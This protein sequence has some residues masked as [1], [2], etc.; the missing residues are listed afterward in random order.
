M[1]TTKIV[2]A[3]KTLNIKFDGSLN[4]QTVSD[5]VGILSPYIT[6]YL[7][8]QTVLQLAGL[9]TLALCVYWICRSTMAYW[10]KGK[11]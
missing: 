8:Q 2:E 9:L 4:S 1:D 7:I 11:P 10:T 3:I 6:W 5:V